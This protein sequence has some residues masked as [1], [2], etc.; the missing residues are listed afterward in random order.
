SDAEAVGSEAVPHESIALA[1]VR[2]PSSRL[3]E[4]TVRRPTSPRRRRINSRA[5]A[6][7]DSA[8]PVG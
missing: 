2:G 6:D 8:R 7:R 3:S 4:A 1:A 5:E